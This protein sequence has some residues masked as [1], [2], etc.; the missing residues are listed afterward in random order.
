MESELNT[1]ETQ[2][3]ELQKELGSSEVLRDANKV[4][5]LSIELA[6]IEKRL[7]ALTRL[8]EIE[9]QID[10]NKTILSG[11][12]EELTIIAGDELKT[13]EHEKR[14]LE[15]KLANVSETL[16]NNI[17][18]EIRAGAGG[19]EAALFARELF[20][21]YTRFAQKKGW[22]VTMLDDSQNNIGG[23]KEVIFEID[24]EHS[25]K[26]LRW[27]SGVHRV[28]RIPETEKSGRVH[29]ST[30]SVA[31]LPRVEEADLE[32]GP[33][34]IK[35]EFSK[36]G[37][38]GGQNVNKV[39]TAVRITHLATGLVVRSQESR[40]QLKNRERAFSILRARLL[41]AKMRAEAKKTGDERRAQIGTGD[42]S[43]KIRTYNFPQD[44]ITDHRIKES[45][46]NIEKVLNGELDPIIQKII[47]KTT[48]PD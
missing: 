29:T 7:S 36:S 37:G 27:E 47:S 39:E 30:A 42:R 2:K 17:I 14:S 23:F 9:Q 46:H 21:M 20:D 35:L 22:G 10:E 41:D 1:L 18:V 34:D 24:G 15:Q 6:K 31:V 33:Q 44:R 28:Q 32:I 26:L 38:A 11:T 40:S 25:Y 3:D 13:L 8:A 12:D 19:D 16:P 48:Q 5:R 45:W 4:K 43:E